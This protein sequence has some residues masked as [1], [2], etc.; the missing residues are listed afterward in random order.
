MPD[1]LRLQE[2]EPGDAVDRDSHQLDRAE[3][4]SILPARRD[5]F[6]QT[7]WVELV[8]RLDGERSRTPKFFFLGLDFDEGEQVGVRE[9]LP[10]FESGE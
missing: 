6:F 1:S 3:H 8:D 10:D 4:L 5:F 2:T 7:F 9:T